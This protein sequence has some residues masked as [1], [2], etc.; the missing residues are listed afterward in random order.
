M[1]LLK[2]GTFHLVI[3]RKSFGCCFPLELICCFVDLIVQLYCRLELPELMYI[4]LELLRIG[5]KGAVAHTFN[6]SRDRETDRIG[7]LQ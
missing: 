7:V 5:S 4:S 2:D 1:V 3:C 6:P